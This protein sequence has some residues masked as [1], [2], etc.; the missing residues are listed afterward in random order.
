MTSDF[1]PIFCI[2]LYFLT[3]AMSDSVLFHVGIKVCIKIIDFCKTIYLLKKPD[4][5]QFPL[6]FLGQIFV[7]F[8]L[9]GPQILDPVVGRPLVGF[10]LK[11]KGLACL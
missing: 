9:N 10:S 5:L 4:F 7:L 1:L 6:G 3:N 2:F 11:P 8:C